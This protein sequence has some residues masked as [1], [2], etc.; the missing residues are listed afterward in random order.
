MQKRLPNLSPLDD[1]RITGDIDPEYIMYFGIGELSSQLYPI[2][3]ELKEKENIPY[4]ALRNIQYSN[5]DFENNTLV[6][7]KAELE[8]MKDLSR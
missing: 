6:F 5:I 2:M 7:S 4:R 3:K 8:K 1:K